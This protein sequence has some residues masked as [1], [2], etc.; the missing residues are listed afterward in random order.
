MKKLFFMSGLLGTLAIITGCSTAAYI[1]QDNSVNFANYKTY[2]WVDTRA[3][4]ND[5]SKRAT[6]YA[7]ISVHN[8]VN[9]Q[10]RSKWGW[11]EVSNDQ[12]ADVLVN[13]DVF[14][15]RSV[16]TQQDP[17][18]SQ[19]VSRY[20]YNRFSRRWSTIYY[21]S[22]FVGYQTY[23]TPVREGTI[24]I[25]MIEANSDK[26]IWQGWTTERL[27]NSGMTDLNIG[28][29]VRNIFKNGTRP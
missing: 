11:T 4:E 29:S 8:A 21:P 18:Y 12:N 23:D 5:E 22:Q 16:Q 15:Q 27:G 9:D 19:P 2:M 3:S 17:V 25:T 28:K 7:D 24:T 10:L 26:K 14:V 13:Y 1:E 20:Y 6:A